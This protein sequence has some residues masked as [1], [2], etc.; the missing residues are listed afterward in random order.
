MIKIH[1]KDVTIV[2]LLVLIVPFF[3]P[4]YFDDIPF[5]DAL[6]NY[7]R[8]FN[9]LIIIPLFFCYK[10]TDKAFISLAL[11][12]ATFLISTLINNV[13]IYT[14]V[15][16]KYI[17]IVIYMGFS[18]CVMWPRETIKLLLLIGEILTYIN[19]I[20]IFLF[21]SGLYVNI[22]TNWFLGFKNYYIPFYWMSLVA[23]FLY[24]RYENRHSPRPFILAFSMAVSLYLVNSSTSILMIALFCGLCIL[25]GNKSYKY[26]NSISFYITNIILFYIVVVKRIIEAFSFI[27]IT[28]FHKNITLSGRT[29]LWDHVISLIGKKPLLGYGCISIEESRRL[30]GL[31]FGTHAHDTILQYIYIGGIISLLFFLIFNFFIMK[32]LFYFRETYTGKVLSIAVFVYYIGCLTE[33]YTNGLIFGLFALANSIEFLV[34]C[35]G[36]YLDNSIELKYVYSEDCDV[37]FTQ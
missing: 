1:D 5:L 34:S 33:T 24:N 27:I 29:L 32:K 19:L 23:A 20:T 21:P 25:L 28:V 31:S 4:G 8:L 3:K 6:F 35:E 11:F 7:V 15:K 16:E 13:S 10:R 30:T 17:Q 26:L 14:F 9:S 12:E 18:L 22:T 2:V 37:K 36:F